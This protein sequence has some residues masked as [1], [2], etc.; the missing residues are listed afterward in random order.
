MSFRS[1]FSMFAVL[2]CTAAMIFG[3]NVT[4]AQAAGSSLTKGETQLTKTTDASEQVADK[5]APMG[6]KEV[7]ERNAGGLNEI[8][9][10]A[11]ADKM[12]KADPSKPG[13]AL[14]NK[15]NKALEKITK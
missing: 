3:L 15:I 7:E 5:S 13:P 2:C 8:Q 12:Y 11:D 4:S 1:V 9:G 14:A 10:D 6:L